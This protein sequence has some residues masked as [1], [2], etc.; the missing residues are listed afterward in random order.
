MNEI[1]PEFVQHCIH[2]AEACRSKLRPDAVAVN[3]KCGLYV[4][5]LLN[6]LCNR[7]DNRHFDFGTGTGASIVAASYSNS[8]AFY[9]VDHFIKGRHNRP[10]FVENTKRFQSFCSYQLIEKDIFAIN[11]SELTPCSSLFWDGLHSD[12]GTRK[13]IIFCDPMFDP[14]FVMVLD[15]W[16]YPQTR[17]GWRGALN[18]MQY[19]ILFEK[20]ISTKFSDKLINDNHSTSRLNTADAII[21]GDP[22]KQIFPWW[23]GVYIAVLAKRRMFL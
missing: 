7:P 9:T 16:N 12:E 13:S 6:N 3:G 8:G 14:V 17:Q 15:D 18:T 20:I 19:R 10:P 21:D 22:N 5:H 4:K 11:V 1:T 2:E 23:N